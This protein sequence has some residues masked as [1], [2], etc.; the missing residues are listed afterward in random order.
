LSPPARRTVEEAERIKRDAKR[1]ARKA[2]KAERRARDA[3]VLQS[4]APNHRQPRERHNGHLAFIRRGLCLSCLVEGAAQ[5]GPT[6]AA[7]IRCSYPEKGWSP[8]GKG[9][10]PSDWRTLPL[11]DWCHTEAPHAQHNSKEKDWWG[12]LGIY[13]PTACAA[14]KAGFENNQDPAEIARK[15]AI[16][17]RMK[18][19]A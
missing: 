16:E 12:R 10:K 9:V 17:A 15:I 2:E 19:A 4:E 14:F 7:H 11:C 3:A 18:G 1:E 6:R 5:T 13:P 8:T